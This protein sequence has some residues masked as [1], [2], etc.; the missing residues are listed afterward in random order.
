MDYN[1]GSVGPAGGLV[2]Y[3]KGSNTDGWRYLEAAPEETDFSNVQ[4]GAYNKTISKTGTAVGTGKQNTQV[5]VHR[6]NQWGE[7]RKAAQLCASLNVN[8]YKDWFLPSKDELDLMYKN[9]K[10]KLLGGFRDN[11][12]WSSSADNIRYAWDQRFSSS[13]QGLHTKGSMFSVRAVRAF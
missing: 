12:Y 13:S 8:G 2:F 1:V 7:S 4:W 9:L 11:W 3:D 6:L 10:M 5:I